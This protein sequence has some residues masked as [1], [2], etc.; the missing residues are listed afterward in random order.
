MTKHIKA[1]KKVWS[2][3]WMYNLTEIGLYWGW[4]FLFLLR[5]IFSSF[6]KFFIIAHCYSGFTEIRGWGINLCAIVLFEGAIIPR[7]L[8]VRG[9]ERKVMK[10]ANEIVCYQ[11]VTAQIRDAFLTSQNSLTRN[12]MSCLSRQSMLGWGTLWSE[13]IP[14]NIIFEMYPE[15]NVT[16]GGVL[17][18]N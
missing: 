13:C 3:K 6:F 7:V 10:E 18:G 2:P 14:P 4:Y 17:G 15:C 12:H 9:K 5:I 8:E 16:E 11:L 1:T